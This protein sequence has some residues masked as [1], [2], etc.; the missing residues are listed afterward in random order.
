MTMDDAREHV[1][2]FVQE[3]EDK[4]HLEPEWLREALYSVPR[5]LF[6]EQ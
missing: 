5:H 3:M 6:I 4:G 1:A 2:A